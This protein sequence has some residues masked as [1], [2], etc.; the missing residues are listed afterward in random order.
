MTSLE[1]AWPL[2]LI[3]F[4]H[5]SSPARVCPDSQLFVDG[6][7]KNLCDDLDCN[8]DN[9]CTFEECVVN[10]Q[11]LTASCVR[12]DA[13][14]GRDCQ[15]SN[16]PGFCNTG[17]CEP[18]TGGAGGNGGAGGAGGAGCNPSDCDDGNDC[19]VD[20]TCNTSSGQCEGGRNAQEDT[21][22]NA[23]TG[24]CDGA[25]ECVECNR[26]QQCDDG[27]EC[28]T[29]SCEGG[30]CSHQVIVNKRC[31][32][33][34]GS[35]N[36]LCDDQGAC[37]EAPPNC[38]PDTC[39]D[40][41]NDCTE[42]TCDP[43]DGSCSLAILD[44]G[45]CTD[46]A[47]GL[48]GTCVQDTCV[49]HCEGKQ[50]PDPPVCQTD[51]TCNVQD[52][53]CEEG[54]PEPAETECTEGSGQVCNGQG[55]CVECTSEAW[56][57][58]Q[59]ECTDDVCNAANS[60]CEN[61]AVADGTACAETPEG[62]CLGGTCVPIAPEDSRFLDPLDIRLNEPAVTATDLVSFPLGDIEDRIRYDVFGQ[63]LGQAKQVFEYDCDPPDTG[64]ILFKNG[65]DEVG[66]GES[67]CRLATSASDTGSI[68]VT[69]Q[70]GDGILVRWTIT[71]SATTQGAISC[72]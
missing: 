60:T 62:A 42:N 3:A 22:C 53:V 69:A 30:S 58:D 14:N 54:D 36:G 71:A 4:A 24:V 37:F 72:P 65:V 70:G 40:T 9:G 50:C 15:G 47:G 28:T 21:P 11:E 29:D 55:S 26:P 23:E 10:E 61:T 27:N 64:Q 59:N 51:A 35:E 18:G 2:L 68:T 7:C 17:Q 5:C 1:R 44:G 12:T 52:G 56:C 20:G 41:G 34:G 63:W 66:C 19:T 67:T 45:E 33:D 39:P 6:Q 16:G 49:G 8:D 25:G 38:G 32:F 48:P 43:S 31:D 13:P 57:D 46:A